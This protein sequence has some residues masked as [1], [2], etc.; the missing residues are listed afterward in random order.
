MTEAV[1]TT[2]VATSSPATKPLDKRLLAAAVGVFVVGWVIGQNSPGG[3]F[4]WQPEK[5]RPVLTA[6]ARLA[7]FGLWL[8]VV[9]PPPPDLPPE[10][11]FVKH[12]PDYISHREGW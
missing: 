10:R 6:L 9:E 5:P 1:V 7:K 4:P 12:D 2:P 8:M 3:S 11:S